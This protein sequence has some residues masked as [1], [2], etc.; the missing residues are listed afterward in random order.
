MTR[1]S[2]EQNTPRAQVDQLR[3]RPSARVLIIGGGIN[4]IA[5]FRDL[6]IVGTPGAY[7]IVFTADGYLPVV[8]GGI[9]AR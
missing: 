5:T 3:K 4:G 6:A 8:S 7:T 2:H 9:E 1:P